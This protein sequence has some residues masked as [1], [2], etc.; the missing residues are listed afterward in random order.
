MSH[1]TSHRETLGAYIRDGRHIITETR[2]KPI[3][4]IA[5]E[6]GMS[7]DTVRYWLKADHYDEWLHY[8]PTAEALAAEWKHKGEVPKTFDLPD[9]DPATDGVR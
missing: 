2:A 4:Q 7:V 5:A 3:R 1:P 6:T 9:F 8:W